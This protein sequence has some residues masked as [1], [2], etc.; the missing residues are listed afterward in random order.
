MYRPNSFLRL[1]NHNT[2][3][4]YT[5]KEL[6]IISCHNRKD[7]HIKGESILHKYPNQIYCNIPYNPLYL[8]QG[9]IPT[10]YDHKFR[11]K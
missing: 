11:K 4:E 2:M 6:F 8:I 9:A 3:V 10:P 1:C 7:S 5:C